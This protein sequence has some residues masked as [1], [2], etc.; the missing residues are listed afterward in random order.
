MIDL[1]EEARVVVHKNEKDE[2]YDNGA[3]KNND[4]LTP[5]GL[6][7]RRKEPGD[8]EPHHCSKE[9]EV[10]YEKPEGHEIEH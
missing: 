8:K 4:S 5:A 10:P 7:A 2:R 1:G 6:N 3:V 9:N